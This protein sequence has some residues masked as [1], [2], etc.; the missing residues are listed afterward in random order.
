MN[1]V[2]KVVTKFKI[3]IQKYSDNFYLYTHFKFT[4]SNKTFRVT[5]VCNLIHIHKNEYVLLDNVLFLKN[6]QQL[7]QTKGNNFD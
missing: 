4:Y 1:N 6:F 7:C 3:L 2:Q 5:S